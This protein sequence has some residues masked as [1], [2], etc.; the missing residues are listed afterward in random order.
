MPQV[1]RS[2][3][4]E[5]RITT[6]K[7]NRMSIDLRST[8]AFATRHIGPSDLEVEEMLNRLDVSSLDELIDEAIPGG[9]RLD[10]PLDLPPA[11]SEHDLLQRA[12]ALASKNVVFRSF[13]G[14]GYHDTVTPPVIQRNVLEN[15]NW[16][17]QYTPYQAEISQGRLEAL[18]TFQTMVIDLTGLEIAN[19]SLLD[20]ATAAAEAMMMFNR[21]SPRRNANVFFVSEDCHPQTID[22][23]KARALPIGVDVVIG[24][25]RTFEFSGEVFGALVQ[26][27]ATDGAVYDYDDFCRRAHEENAFVVV[28]A[29]ILS[30]ALLRPPGAFGA[31]AAIGNTQRFGVPLGFGGPHAA[32]FATRE[33][34][35]RQ[36]P[37]RIIG[38]SIDADGDPALRMALQTRE[39]H[40]RRDKA[41]SNICTA[42][43]L[44]AIMAAMYAVYHGPEGLRSIAERVHNLA[45][46]LE[47]GFRRLGCSVRHDHFFDTL[48]VEPGKTGTDDVLAAASR[49]RINLRTFTD[50]SF[51]IALDETISAEDINALFRIFGGEGNGVSAETLAK[52]MNPGYAGPLPRTSS[53]LDHSVFHRYHSETEMMRYLH[54]LASR[55]LSLTTS[56][57]PLGSCTMKLN[58]AAELLPITLPGFN[59]L[60][61]CVPGDQAAGYRELIDEL[62]SWL[63]EITGFAKTSFQPNSG[64]AG[65]YTGLLVI[66]AYHRDR[67]E[68]QRD[69]C[70]IPQSAHGTNPASATMAGMKVVVVKTDKHGNVDVDDL[71]EKAEKYSDELAALMITY[72]S[73]HGVFEKDVR[74]INRIVHEHGGQ[75]YLDGANMNAQVGLCRPGDYGADVCHLN[76][77]KTF[78]IPHGGGGPGMGPICVAQHLVP[79]LPAHPFS[80]ADDERAIGPVAAAPYGSPNILVISWAYIAMMGASGLKRA[81][82]I[83]ILN[84]NYMMERIEERYPVLYKGISGRC[85]HE[86]L[87]DLRPIKKAS[88]ITELDIAKRLMDYGYHAPTM[89]FPV[90][91]TIMIEP[92]ESE[93]KEEL[94][95]F[96]DALE[97]IRNEIDEIATGSA[98]AVHNALK[99]SPHTALMVTSDDWD[100]PYGREQAAF[101]ASWTRGHKFWP[102]VRRVDDAYGDRNLVC[103]CPPTEAYA[104]D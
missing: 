62:D 37:G 100:E 45:R 72:P 16:Y 76:L 43:V 5:V 2:I 15:P 38:V 67:G 82:E 33:Q 104:A 49:A 92:T 7:T 31:D 26:Y 14:M 102:A 86:F 20:E 103:V 54:R 6:D 87:V 90:P 19:A 80:D 9:I 77:H 66:E 23:V 91:G 65:E 81:S 89:S 1:R 71:R 35:K 17:T 51:G 63:C 75:V 34:F 40:I 10:R 83:A 56:M 93:T 88:D 99:N 55:D 69:V 101:P 53:Y 52:D 73:T 13:I 8:E 79:F 47:V 70:L 41:T 21:A 61:P 95:R 28:A 18:L 44:L 58:A 64:A 25:H 85:A 42:Q 96:C 12:H 57:I 30:L 36:I 98:D 59:K 74:T 94:D 46:L 78:C 50:G 22:V 24:D 27:P 3:G 60:H 84:A 97:L 39:Q 11:A 68:S 29:D 32:Y 4:F 48:R